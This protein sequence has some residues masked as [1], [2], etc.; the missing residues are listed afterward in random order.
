MCGL[1]S[2]PAPLPSL[3]SLSISLL[4]T[5]THTHRFPFPELCFENRSFILTVNSQA[6]RYSLATLS[7]VKSPGW[8]S[9]TE[10]THTLLRRRVAEVER[11][12]SSQT[13]TWG[14]QNKTRGEFS[15]VDEMLILLFWVLLTGI[16]LYC[17]VKILYYRLNYRPV[18]SESYL[19]GKI[20]HLNAVT[21]QSGATLNYFILFTVR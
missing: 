12:K 2:L 4:H 18:G 5:H 17:S 6:D 8:I 15:V 19:S 11:H 7:V 3:A 14:M 1:A 20:T 16:Q 21:A 10:Y 9:C 13:H